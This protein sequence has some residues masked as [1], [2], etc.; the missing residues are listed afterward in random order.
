MRTTVNIN[1]SLLRQAK[2]TSAERNCTLGEVIDDAL[3]VAL[4]QET[5]GT[6]AGHP[7]IAPLKTFRG[8]GVQTGVD[9]TN[10][11][12]LLDTMES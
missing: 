12:A 10:S 5:A 8:N 4:A 11:A 1:D 2:K 3:R 7:H 9:L 6:Q